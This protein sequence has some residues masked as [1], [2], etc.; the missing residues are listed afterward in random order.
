MF[1]LE[2]HCELL[3][4]PPTHPT[5]PPG[6]IW[7]TFTAV[8]ANSLIVCLF[9]KKEKKGRKVFAVYIIRHMVCGQDPNAENLCV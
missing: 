4:L 2:Q 5:H 7:G 9:L 6:L 8:Y 3:L 1:A